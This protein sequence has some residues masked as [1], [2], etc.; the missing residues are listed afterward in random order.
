MSSLRVG[1]ATWVLTAGLCLDAAG[2]APQ[3]QG[4]GPRVLVESRHSQVAGAPN[5]E[6]TARQVAALI[7]E[8]VPRI[9]PIVGT[10][11]LG[12]VAARIYLD[13]KAFVEATGIPRRSRVTGLATFPAGVI[14]IDGTGLLATI[15]RVVPHEVGHIMIAR[16]VGRAL[17]SLP[18]WTNE[19]IAEYVAGETSTHVDPVWVRAVGRGAAL[20]LAELD[21]AI[22]ERGEGSGLAYAEAASLVNF[23]VNRHGEEVIADL[24]RSLARTH[25]FE[26]SLQEVTGGSIEELETTWR[27]SVVRAW[28]WPLLAQSPILIYG[29]MALLFVIGLARYLRERRRRQE[30]YEQDEGNW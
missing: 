15:E 25:D 4:E 18:L 29:L 23:L 9:A 2:A 1:W 20:E 24:L 11:N 10:D 12:P 14:H 21:G 7:D 16:A 8:A 28:R 26:A 19:G 6:Q 22:A 17:P 30:I 3:A 5:A 27:R 13:R